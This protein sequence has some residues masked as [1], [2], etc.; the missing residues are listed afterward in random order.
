ML[1]VKEPKNKNEDEKFNI[2]SLVR[3][4]PIKNIDYDDNIGLIDILKEKFT[5]DD[6]NL[7]LMHF[8][9]YLKFDK[10][11]DFVVDFNNVWKWLEFTRL[12]HCKT[13]L[14]KNFEENIDYVIFKTNKNTNLS[15]SGKNLG[16]SGLNKENIFLNIDCFKNLCLLANKPKS[17]EIRKY[18]IKLEDTITEFI[19]NKNEELRNNLK[20]NDLLKEEEFTHSEQVLLQN[21]EGKKTFYLGLV[22]KEGE[23]PE[24]AKTIKF[25]TTKRGEERVMREHK[26]DF[27]GNFTLRYVITSERYIEIE[28]KLKELC[29]DK[30]SMLYGRQ[31][32]KRI[33]GKMQTELIRLDD[34]F[35][36]KDLYK[37]MLRIQE[38]CEDQTDKIKKLKETIKK[39]NR[40]LEKLKNIQNSTNTS[41][42]KLDNAKR[43]KE[44]FEEEESEEI[45]EEHDHKVCCGHYDPK[46][47]HE[48]EKHNE[49]DEVEEINQKCDRCG[50]TEISRFTVNEN[51]G[52]CYSYCD[53]CRKEESD[54]NF[55]KNKVKREQTKQ[56]KEKKKEELEKINAKILAGTKKFNCDRCK[57]PKLPIE[58]G[59]RE[60]SIL[61]KRC[62]DCRIKEKKEETEEEE[63]EETEMEDVEMS[64][65]P[66]TSCNKQF[67][68]ERYEFGRT[69]YVTCKACREKDKQKREYNKKILDDPNITEI[70]CKGCQQYFPKEANAHKDGP[71][72]HCQDCRKKTKNIIMK[73]ENK[74]LSKRKFTTKKIK[75][76]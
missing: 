41:S 13:L 55:E 45:Q 36:H 38:E 31:F 64:P 52:Q 20:N 28:T 9:C 73:I 62:I 4:N 71:L 35:T 42:I 18:Y 11:K 24:N 14:L 26:R 58:F 3:D 75:K 23:A 37:E 32:G 29:K 54:K 34:N 16:G 46:Y 61:Y 43:K 50:T 66:C 17:K 47:D 15:E 12:D 19:L 70:E 63:I 1:K 5:T 25:G 72:K 56:E 53:I 2:V 27:K 76:K 49:D 40:E 39:Q 51:T 69:D 8:Y 6:E 10:Y 48:E 44:V 30:T 21:V 22:N 7:F 33:N 57:K 65:E 59:I 60:K 74:S 68:K 67:P